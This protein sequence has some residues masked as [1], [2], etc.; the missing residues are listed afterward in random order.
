MT[1]SRFEL[2]SSKFWPPF[3]LWALAF[4]VSSI[5]GTHGIAYWD[6]GDY[7]LLAI[8]GGKSGL[9][10]GRPLFL[11]IS[12]LVL[13]TGVEPVNAEPVLRWFWAAVGA[14]AA[15]ALAVLASRLGLDRRAAL[16]AGAALALS[17][18][19]AHTSHQVLTDAPALA[20]SIAALAAA[21][22]SQP[23]RAG[24]LL[25]AAIATRETAAVH[26][27]SL[28]L[29]LER[30][31]AIRA[32]A[33]C[34][35]VL[36][37]IV[38]IHQPPGVIAWVTALSRSMATHSWTF[39]DLLTSIAWVLAAGPVP[40][41]VGIVVLVRGDA[42]KQVRFV[43]V[44]AAAA[45]ALLLFYPDGSF[46]PRYVLATAPIAFFIAAAPW[47]AARKAIVAAALLVPLAAAVI[48]AR[49]ANVV[50]RYGA[51]LNDRVSQL[52]RD[53]VV[54][55]GHFCPQARLAAAVAGRSDLRFVC[56]GWDWP[57]DVA[58]ELDDAVRQGRSVAV[59]VADA[60]W[61]GRRE[62]APREAV[63]AWVASRPVSNVSGF[64][65]VRRPGL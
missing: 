28:A 53:A 30:R 38:V 22:S 48:A 39:S 17:P 40:V 15:P 60:A 49:P 25:A 63:R 32:L 16:V 52:P 34:T 41:I 26:V 59:D 56:P 8:N 7:T 29:L 46:S 12:R 45:T 43:A 51:T 18:S 6:A 14:C 33:A 42:H 50:A 31:Q 64:S 4:I 24:I 62:V 61:I 36:V 57:A 20:L 19:F 54:V 11:W 27:V 55:P 35:A 2:R 10:L 3:I 23:W 65:V 5:I 9:L 37:A 1:T 13:R 21:A 44:P 47:L 58:A